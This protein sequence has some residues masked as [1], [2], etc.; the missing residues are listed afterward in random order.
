MATPVTAFVMPGPTWL[1]THAGS[2][3]D[4]GVA[5]G[6]VGGDL[7][8]AD[9][10]ERDRL[11]AIARQQRDVGVPAEPEDVTDTAALEG[12]DELLG[13]GWM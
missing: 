6:G 2:A 7:L 13:S 11:L 10:D 12:A 1:S 5:V 3:G 9:D 8:V 4:A